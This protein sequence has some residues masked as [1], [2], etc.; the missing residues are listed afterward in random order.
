PDRIQV[1]V[2]PGMGMSRNASGTA[3]TC[4]KALDMAR[5]PAPPVSTSVPSMSKRRICCVTPAPTRSGLLH[6]DGDGRTHAGNRVVQVVGDLQ[7]ELVLARR[8]LHV[9]LRLAVAKMDP[10]RR[11]LDDGLSWSEAG[12]VHAHVVVTDAG[13]RGLDIALRHGRDFDSFRSELEVR[14]T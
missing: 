11:P 2:R 6:V 12:L 5:T 4:S 8:Q 3:N 7:R 13:T 10:R 1:S 9:D 14:R